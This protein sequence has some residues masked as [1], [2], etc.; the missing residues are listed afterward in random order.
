MLHS[1]M[2]KTNI[3]DKIKECDVCKHV[4]CFLLLLRKCTLF[5]KFFLTCHAV[6]TT[7][8]FSTITYIS[9]FL[10]SVFLTGSRI[11]LVSLRSPRTHLCNIVVIIIIIFIIIIVVLMSVCV[12]S[13]VSVCLCTG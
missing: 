7:T 3:S 9:V 1:D 5:G 13:Y 8:P 10:I 11:T 6:Y 4:H 2:Y 12:S